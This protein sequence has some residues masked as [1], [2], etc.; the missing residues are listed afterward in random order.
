MVAPGQQTVAG[1]DFDAAVIELF[2]EAPSASGDSSVRL[3]GAMAVDRTSGVLLR[4][5]LRSTNPDFAL[6]RR[7]QRVDPA[8]TP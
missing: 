7:L 5:D 4:L 6:R 3:D 1:R 8:A 2:G